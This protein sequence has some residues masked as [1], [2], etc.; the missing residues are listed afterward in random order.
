[1]R[2]RIRWRK[3]TRFSREVLRKIEEQGG[4]KKCFVAKNGRQTKVQEERRG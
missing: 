4:V 2:L 3:P 1:M